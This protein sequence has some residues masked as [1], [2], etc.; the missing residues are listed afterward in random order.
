MLGCLRNSS[1]SPVDTVYHIFKPHTS[2]GHVE[3]VE[4]NHIDAMSSLMGCSIA[5]FDMIIEAMSDGGVKNGVPR[6]ISYTLAAKAME[7]AAKLFLQSGKHAG[8]VGFFL[9]PTVAF[10]YD[11]RCETQLT[12]PEDAMV[13][14]GFQ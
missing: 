4:E 8:Q 10:I 2:L 6:K 13:L 12:Y 1:V 11:F 5:W 14:S 7:G 9:S 3:E